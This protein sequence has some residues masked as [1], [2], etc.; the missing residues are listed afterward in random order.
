M[1]TV[2][3]HILLPT[4]FSDLA[5]NA[6]ITAVEMCKRHDAHLHILH[7]VENRIMVAP[8]ESNVPV[9]Y[10]VPEMEKKGRENLDALVKKLVR[11]HNIKIT[12]HLEFGNPA[13][14]IRDKAI[15]L[16]CELIVIGTHGASGFRDLFIGSTAYTLIKNTTIPVLT[17]PGKRK[18]K[19]FG[20]VL[21]PIRAAKGI[22]EK[23]DFIEPIIEKNNS[24]LVILGLSLQSE[25]FNLEDRKKELLE[26]GKSL[27][28]NSTAFSSQFQVCKNY[29]RTV[30]DVARKEKVQLIVINATLDYSWSEFFIGPYAQ[31]II[32]HAKIPVL[33]IRVPVF[34]NGGTQVEAAI[35]R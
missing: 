30:L 29:A 18:F 34:K 13:D 31:Q 2:L 10:V 4:D 8:P 28:V 26:L 9:F 17:I 1:K 22:L 21:F 24:E 19:N 23:Y 15:E 12:A 5:G 3:K 14:F 11:K 25:I 6:T 35:S 27:A 20:K 7:V 32:N 16:S 33:S